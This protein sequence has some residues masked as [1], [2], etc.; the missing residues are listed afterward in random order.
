MSKSLGN[1]ID[2][3]HVINGRS[4]A[5]LEEDLKLSGGPMMAE[6]ELQKALKCLKS[7]F[8]Q[9]IPKC[10]TD[11]L[12]FSLVHND[13]KSQQLNMD[14]QFVNTCSA[15]CNKIW[16]VAR[17][18]ILSHER[19]QGAEDIDQKVV[20]PHLTDDEV[21]NWLIK[22]NE[23]M[24]PEDQ[25]ILCRCGST[26]QDVNSHLEARDFHLAARCLRTFIY[27]NLC[28]VYVEIA[29]PVLSDVT[30]PHF[31][32]KYNIIKI[33]LLT[34]LKLLHPI[35]PFIT[36]EI[37]QRIRATSM[38]VSS[39]KDKMISIMISEYPN[40]EDWSPLMPKNILKEMNTTLEFVT[41]I[42]TIKSLYDLKRGNKPDVMIIGKDASDYTPFHNKNSKEDYCKLMS[43][44][45]PCGK[46]NIIKKG[47]NEVDYSS[48]L[49]TWSS[50]EL[51]Q[52]NSTLYV[53]VSEH[54][55]L[56]KELQKISD[57]R[58]KLLKEFDKLNRKLEKRRE[59]ISQAEL[60]KFNT[61]M[62]LL[63]DKQRLLNK[64]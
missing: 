48:N 59:L 38:G 8:P 47:E 16:Q 51:S 15:F 17:F 37:Y 27:T 56:N 13:P 57:Q 43:I 41:S 6:K 11:A 64:I 44:L 33:C 21:L 10:G 34:G 25:W 20:I 19:L 54:L 22:S 63:N 39:T 1:V 46:V 61:Q 24:K 55:D 4:L 62:E 31:Q 2:P 14:V 53:N 9:G 7:T 40:W 42:R 32:M 28:D 26:V 5:Q 45:S 29:K 60:E 50:V 52:Y 35:M 23:I 18:F 36:E 58:S 3:V 49:D 12:R 30:N